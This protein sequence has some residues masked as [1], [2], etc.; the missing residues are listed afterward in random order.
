MELSP[1]CPGGGYHNFKKPAAEVATV[2]LF[3]FLCHRKDSNYAYTFSATVTLQLTWLQLEKTKALTGLG[4]ITKNQINYNYL[5][6]RL[7][8]HF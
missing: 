4:P 8:L 7:Q 6:V 3:C 5:S 1:R 2:G